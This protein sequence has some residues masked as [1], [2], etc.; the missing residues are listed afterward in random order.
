MGIAALVT[1]VLTA[2]GG[3]VLL[4]T[5]ISHGGLTQ[6]HVGPTR[7]P[8]ALVFS[9]FLLAA[10]G[11]VLWIVYLAVDNH[12][13][14]WVAFGLLVVVAVLGDTM[15]L[16]WLPAYRARHAAAAGQAA[17][18]TGGMG[19][20][21]AAPAERHLPLPVVAGHGLLAVTTLVLVFLAALLD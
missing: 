11:L 12:G 14:A 8:S 5:W 15:F 18:A 16:R 7:F 21:P 19:A 1:W 3:F 20:A 9:H 17:G 4:G 2:L 6:Q 10:G 13:L